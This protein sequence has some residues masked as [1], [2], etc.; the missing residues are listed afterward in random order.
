MRHLITAILA[1]AI[2]L[3][4]PSPCRAGRA[5]NDTVRI[6]VYI[7]PVIRAGSAYDVIVEAANLSD[8]PIRVG[9]ELCMDT[10]FGGVCKPF[11]VLDEIE[12][13]RSISLAAFL[14]CNEGARPGIYRVVVRAT[15]EGAV[16]AVRRKVRIV[17]AR[18]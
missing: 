1:I 16:L 6:D 5:E 18:P 7:S 2:G 12:P 17:E 9:F 14:L 3:A 11:A 8:R 4:L 13:N 10:P 15:C